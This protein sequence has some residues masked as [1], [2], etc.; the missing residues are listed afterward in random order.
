M[1]SDSFVKKIQPFVATHGAD[2]VDAWLM[3]HLCRPLRAGPDT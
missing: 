3:G 2:M 1:I